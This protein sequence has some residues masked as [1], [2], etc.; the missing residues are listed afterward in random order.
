MYIFCPGNGRV[1]MEWGLRLLGE[2]SHERM[3]SA[4]GR[5]KQALPQVDIVF[6]LSHGHAQDMPDDGD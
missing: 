3:M 4:R 2:V 5:M 1:K 6:E